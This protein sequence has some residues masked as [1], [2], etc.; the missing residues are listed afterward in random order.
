[1]I[2]GFV[3]G[4]ED[5]STTGTGGTGGTIVAGTG[6]AV[7]GT[8]GAVVGTGGATATGG[9]V[10]ATGGAVGAGSCLT[11]DGTGT[12]TRNAMD[13]RFE[14]GTASGYGFAYIS[15][16]AGAEAID[17]GAAG[18]TATGICASGTVPAE[19]TYAAVAGIGVNVNQ[20]GGEG[21][22]EVA[23]AQTV[24][25]LTVNYTQNAAG[26][27]RV[28][29][30][31]TG[32]DFCYKLDN[33]ATSKALVPADFN[34]KCW[35]ATGTAWDGTGLKSVQLII[36]SSNTATTPFDACLTGVTLTP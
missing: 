36:P 31:T 33:A 34:S 21:T 6:G 23:Y 9:S 17:C 8:G 4:C 28:Q 13:G 19:A 15:P 29:V 11:T 25:G 32:G 1:M 18:D 3:V 20:P 26:T 10:G 35:D 7:V 14:S 2:L 5:G 24:T 16:S 22:T 30:S 27:L 12:F